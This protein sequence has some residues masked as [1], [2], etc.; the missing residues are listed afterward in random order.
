MHMLRK[1]LP[2]LL[3]C[4]LFLAAA[5]C[6]NMGVSGQGGSGRDKS[7]GGSVNIPFFTSQNTLETGGPAP[8][9]LQ[10]D[11]LARLLP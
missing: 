5:G 10:P 8:V 9:A 1:C 4:L 11:Q 6:G 3:V 2:F 7:G